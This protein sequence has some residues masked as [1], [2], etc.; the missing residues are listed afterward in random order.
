MEIVFM[1]TCTKCGAENKEDAKFCSACGATFGQVERRQNPPRDECFGLP[2]G[3]AIVG[4]F[5]GVII[6]IVGLSNMFGWE[7]DVGPFATI[8]VGILFIAGALYYL[9][10]RRRR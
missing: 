7:I 5:I 3:G 8:I 6:I 4:L 9:L 2:H 1:V 10:T